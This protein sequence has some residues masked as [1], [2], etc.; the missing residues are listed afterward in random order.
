[1]EVRIQR[2]FYIKFFLA[3]GGLDIK[4]IR[5]TRVKTA[6]QFTGKPVE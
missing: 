2:S 1:M 6:P 3:V 4:E 5:I